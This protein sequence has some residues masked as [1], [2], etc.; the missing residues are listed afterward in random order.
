MAIGGIHPRRGPGEGGTDVFIVLQ[1]TKGTAFDAA[2]SSFM[3]KFAAVATTDSGATARAA[4]LFEEIVP[5]TRVSQNTVRCR[6]PAAPAAVT[7]GRE[8]RIGVSLN[9]RRFAMTAVG[10]GFVYTP[11]ESSVAAAAAA[12]PLPAVV[13]VSPPSGPR[14]GGTQIVIYFASPA[15]GGD[16]FEVRFGDDG[17]AVSAFRLSDTRLRCTTPPWA[18]R[19]TA[20]GPPAPSRVPLFLSVNGGPHRA[21][22]A[23]F[24]Y[25]ADR[26]GAAGATAR[27]TSNDANGGSTPGGAGGGGGGGGAEDAPSLASILP[28]SG[29]SSG[30]TQLV[31]VGA[32]F[33]TANRD[34]FACL[35]NQ[36]VSSTAFRISPGRLQCTTPPLNKLVAERAGDIPAGEFR[37]V[38]PFRVPFGVTMNGQRVDTGGAAVWFTVHPGSEGPTHNLGLGMDNPPPSLRPPVLEHLSPPSGPTSGGT[39]VGVVGTGFGDSG[40]LNGMFSCI[41]ARVRASDGEDSSNRNNNNIDNSAG[42]DDNDDIVTH[43]VRMSDQRVVCTSPAAG[44]T[45]VTT[46]RV[47]PPGGD[48]AMV[49]NALRFSYYRNTGGAGEGDAAAE[50][51]VIL[52]KSCLVLFLFFFCFCF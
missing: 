10:R 40:T 44:R 37:R 28:P 17:P 38:P 4:P 52:A 22:N 36:T 16:D 49:S 20:A 7:D 8:V 1:N 34:S 30:G 24:R 5:A 19:L 25:A 6:S 43:G 23:T 50:G 32:G 14:S 31:V 47:A 35:F 3:C 48:A 26:P 42:G 21:T 18:A 45:G 41:W 46:L 9:N 51:W 39:Q 33:G 27:T 12:S 13:R 29:P 11:S 2:E 15:R